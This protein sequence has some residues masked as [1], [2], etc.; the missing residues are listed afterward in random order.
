MNWVISFSASE[1]LLQSIQINILKINV[2]RSLQS[3][4]N[5]GKQ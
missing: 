5:K 1:I 4:K 3:D 2:L